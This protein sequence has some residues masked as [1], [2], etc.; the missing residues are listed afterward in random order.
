[1]IDGFRM[2]KFNDDLLT[3]PQDR[4]TAQE[5]FPA[6]FHV[7][8]DEELRAVFKTF[9]DPANRAKKRSLFAP[10]FWPSCLS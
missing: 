9:D 1:M 6:L 8:D 7:L 10:G 3:D 2:Q 5:A 4:A